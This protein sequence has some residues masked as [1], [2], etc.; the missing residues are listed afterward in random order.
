MATYM[1][2]ISNL[3]ALLSRLDPVVIFNFVVDWLC[4]TEEVS[5]SS[6]SATK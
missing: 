2:F 5:V 6:F 4:D 3:F 1:R